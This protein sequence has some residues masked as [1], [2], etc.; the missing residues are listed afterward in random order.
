MIERAKALGHK[1]LIGGACTEQEISLAFQKSLGFESIGVFKSVG[2][3]FDRWLDVEHTQLMLD[4][5]P[6]GCENAPSR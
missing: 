5:W 6:N 4:D 3:K 2:Y 1:T